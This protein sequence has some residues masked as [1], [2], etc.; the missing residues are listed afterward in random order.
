MANSIRSIQ[1]QSSMFNVNVQ[2]ST[3]GLGKQL[4]TVDL[5]TLQRRPSC[6]RVR[7]AHNAVSPSCVCPRQGHRQIGPAW[8]INASNA[9]RSRLSS[10]IRAFRITLPLLSFAKETS[11]FCLPSLT[12]ALMRASSSSIAR[13]H[14]LPPILPDRP[15]P[16]IP[17]Q[18]AVNLQGA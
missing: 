5:L 15:E 6:R 10:T 12:I 2:H 13:C 4:G 17:L 1:R 8:L 9:L 18:R 7:I 11:C 16:E 14:Q 3:L